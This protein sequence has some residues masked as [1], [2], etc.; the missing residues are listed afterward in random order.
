MLHTP[1]I[2]SGQ[3]IS[4]KSSRKS[5][6]EIS[7]HQVD[8][9]G[10]GNTYD[11]GSLED[12]LVADPLSDRFLDLWNSTAKNNTEIFAKCFHPVPHDGVRNWKD[13]EHFY[14]DFFA[15]KSSSPP[16]N[17]PL[18]QNCAPILA[19]FPLYRPAHPRPHH[20]QPTNPK[21]LGPPA[22]S[23]SNTKAK[24]KWGHIVTSEFPPGEQ[25]VRE[26][27]ETLG[28]VRGTLVEM[29]LQF[30]IEEDIAKEGMGLNAFTEEVYT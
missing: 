15:S 20:P 2:G 22:S 11:F 21:T 10:E 12:E 18:S 25:G 4:L 7:F 23:D 28:R 30:L 9:R 13:Y 1:E 17:K 8:G 5:K 6:A 3:S 14:S 19:P 24:H 16:N 26:V 27:K 29:P